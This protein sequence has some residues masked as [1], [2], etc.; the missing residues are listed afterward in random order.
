MEPLD[1][2][3]KPPR[4]P[5][6][7]L[8]GLYMLARSI[9]KMRAE[10]PGGK[11]GTYV[12]NRG[13]TKLLLDMLGVT[14]DQFREAVATSDS[15]DDVVRWLRERADALKFPAI[16]DRLARYT[17][18]DNPPERWD[19]IDTVYPNRPPGPRDQVKVFDLLE[20]DDREMFQ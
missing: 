7:Q 10:L 15:D 1:L 4:G 13:L 6:V 8:D 11:P 17:L 5:R 19:F 14:N 2:T 3:G 18:A 12:T 9:D 20:A 16:N